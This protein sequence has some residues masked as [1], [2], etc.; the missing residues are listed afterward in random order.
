MD[1]LLNLTLLKPKYLFLAL[2]IQMGHGVR[3]K[4]TDYWSTLDQ[5][6]TPFYGT[7]MKRD[8]YHHIL[9]YLHFT[10]NRNEPDMTDKK[11]DRLWKIRDLFEILNATF[12]KFYN[13][14]DNLAIDKVIVSFKGRVIFKE[15][16]PKKRKRFGIKM[17]KLCDLTGYTYDM[18]VYWG[19][20]RQRMAQHVTSTH[21]TVT[22]LTGKIEGCGH[23]LY[24]DSFF[25]SPEFFDD[26]VKKQIYCCGTVR[27]NRKGM[28]Q[29]LRPKT[30]KLK[31]GDI[32]VRT[33]AD[34]M[35]ILWRNKRDICMLTNIHSAPAD[36]NFYSEGGKAI[37]TQIV[38]DYNYHMGYVDKGDRMVNSSSIRRRTFKWMKKLFFHLL[39]LAI[40]NSYILHSSCGGKKMSHRNF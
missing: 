27:P 24:M 20:D 40:L 16:I 14:S 29:D 17:F 28:P 25:S 13:P 35:A 38:M 8:R 19:K 9:R 10:D 26:L 7:M 32:C 22:E 15:Y 1:P 36:G 5:L 37:K 2:T 34:L 21:V 3:D 6:Y 31:R 23:K 12:S 33:R 11:F 30:T 39:D 4:L 18:K